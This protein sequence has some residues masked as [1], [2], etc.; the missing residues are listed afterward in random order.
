MNKLKNLLF[1]FLNLVLLSLLVSCNKD[2]LEVPITN[3]L[4]NIQDLD[5]LENTSKNSGMSAIYTDRSGTIKVQ[6]FFRHFKGQNNTGTTRVGSGYVLIGG[7]ASASPDALLTSSAPLLDGKS[8]SASSKDHQYPS[9][10]QLS[11]YAIGLKIEGVSEFT[12]ARNIKINS[13]S[14][15]GLPVSSPSKFVVL[16]TNYT[17]VGGGA[18]LDASCTLCTGGANLLYKSAPLG[19]NAWNTAGKDHIYPGESGLTAYAIGINTSFLN[20]LNIQ[21][22]NQQKSAFVSN[23]IGYAGLHPDSGS[24]LIGVGAEATYNGS[25]RLLTHISPWGNYAFAQSKDHGYADSGHTSIYSW[26]LRKR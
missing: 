7:G 17:L 11:V 19:R 13:E 24:V 10:H 3:N 14:T 26:S 23:S 18:S 1:L 21:V 12:L 16:D 22:I 9:N 8:W 5:Q 4:E 6:V 25:G 15:T 20:S 2:E